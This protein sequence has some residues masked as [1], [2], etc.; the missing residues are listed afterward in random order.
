MAAILLLLLWSDDT[1][2]FYSGADRMVITTDG[3]VGIGDTPAENLRVSGTG[4]VTTRIEAT[5]SKS[6]YL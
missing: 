5:D 6:V 1:L 3:K 2:R 4:T